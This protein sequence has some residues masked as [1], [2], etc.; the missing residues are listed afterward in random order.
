MY[1]SVS[2]CEIFILIW[3]DNLKSNF[4]YNHMFCLG[5]NCHVMLYIVYSSCFLEM[6]YKIQNNCKKINM[7]SSQYTCI[8]TNSQPICILEILIYCTIILYNRYEILLPII[9]ITKFC[10]DTGVI[11]QMKSIRNQTKHPLYSQT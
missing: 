5:T 6:Q 7:L 3:K 9:V 10:S 1:V 11:V 8:D 2:G 4:W